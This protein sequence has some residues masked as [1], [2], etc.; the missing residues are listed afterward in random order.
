MAISG[1]YVSS[2]SGTSAGALALVFISIELFSTMIYCAQDF[3]INQDDSGG[4]LLKAIALL[5]TLGS[6]LTGGRWR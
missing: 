4:D 2:L 5:S 3:S 1:I 6:R